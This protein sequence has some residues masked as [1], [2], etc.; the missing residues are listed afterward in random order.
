MLWSDSAV[1]RLWIL[2]SQTIIAL[3]HGL[4]IIENKALKI[5]QAENIKFVASVLFEQPA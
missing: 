1:Q 4:I 3:K 5:L 2:A